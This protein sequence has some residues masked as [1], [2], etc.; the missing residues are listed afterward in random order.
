MPM[1]FWGKHFLVT[2][3]PREKACD[4][5]IPGS[6]GRRMTDVDHSQSKAII[7]LV[8]QGDQIKDGLRSLTNEDLS[9][10]F[11]REERYRVL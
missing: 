7:S 6:K 3:T 2:F 9:S 11:K 5:P 1:Q 4:P 8:S 10:V